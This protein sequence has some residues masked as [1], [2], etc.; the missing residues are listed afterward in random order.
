MKCLIIASGRGSRLATRSPSKPLTPVLGLPLIARVILKA[1]KAGIKEF[2]I[3][4]GYRGKELQEYLKL[5]AE[6][7]RLKI[8]CLHNENWERENG[9][10]VLKAKDVIKE[11]FIL[12]MSDHIIDENIIKKLKNQKISDGEVILAVDSNIKN[13]R[14]V[15]IDD[16]TKVIVKDQRVVDIGKELESYNA[17]DTGVF[18]CTPAIFK[19]LKQSSERGNTSLSGGMKILARKSCVKAFDVNGNY[20]IDV[21]DEAQLMR[22]EHHLTRILINKECDGPVAKYI[23]RPF[24]LRITKFLMKT[25]IQPNTITVFCFLISIIAA[26][27]LSL[28]GYLPLAIG[29]VLAQ[30]ASILD[31]CDGEI[32]RLKD[33][34]TRFG[35]WFDAV[36]DR[37]ADA[38]LLL[39]LTYH[40]FQEMNN[41]GVIFLGA[42]ALIGSLIN[43]YTAEKYDGFFSKKRN[44][45]FRIGRDLRIFIIFLGGLFNQP[46]AALV[47]I[48]FLMNIENIRRIVVLSRAWS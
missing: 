41:P 16:A 19:A 15:N 45:Y 5:F 23:N 35:G 12:L 25:K 24:S 17:Y 29:A 33:L 10:S 34:E 13:N 22:A 26:L 14:F 20:W 8:T 4:T 2:Y 46:L 3:V 7:R 48:A 32:A 43:S 28:K 9:L 36:L 11:K 47:L 1:R 18:L 42:A 30:L 40:I 31:G 39:G 44:Q 38:L 37:Y 27:F 6:E 21:D